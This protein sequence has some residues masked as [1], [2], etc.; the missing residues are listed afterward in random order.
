MTHAPVRRRRA[1]RRMMRDE[2]A[3]LELA[4]ELVDGLD[5]RAPRHAR[6]VRFRAV[7]AGRARLARG[8]RVRGI[9]IHGGHGDIGLSRGVIAPVDRR[10]L[11]LR[12]AAP[13]EGAATHALGEKAGPT[14]YVSRATASETRRSGAPP[15]W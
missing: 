14:R 5:E 1:A 11:Q 2:L 15:W 9:G 8:L 6:A 4:P 13:W 3:L 12:F 10:R 7:R